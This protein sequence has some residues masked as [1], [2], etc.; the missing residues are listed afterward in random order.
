MPR[1]PCAAARSSWV[2]IT[3]SSRSTT[4]TGTP[5]PAEAARGLEAQHAAT[6]DDGVLGVDR[7]GGDVAG[8]VEGAQ[9]VDVPRLRVQPGHAAGRTPARRWPAPAGRRAGGCRRT[10]ARPRTRGRSRRRPTPRQ[11]V[12]PLGSPAAAA[13][14]PEVRAAGE[15]LGEQDPVVGLVLLCAD[16]LDL[17]TLPPGSPRTSSSTN[18]W[19]TMPAPT[20]TTFSLLMP[21][22]PAP[23]VRPGRPGRRETAQ[24]LNSGIPETGSVASL[25]TAFA[26]PSPGQWNGMN[27]VSG[28]IAVVIR[29]RATAMP[30]AEVTATSSPSST[31]SRLGERR[32]QLDERSPARPR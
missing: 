2:A 20:T 5:A 6:E 27:T 26:M 15:H 29:A 22:P 13:R 17:D 9:H 25:V 14:A 21:A 23:W 8:V 7:A 18:R 10:A 3:W 1:A 16:Q 30:R 19:P 24:T 12:H 4:V 32:V 11:N 31:P 28:R